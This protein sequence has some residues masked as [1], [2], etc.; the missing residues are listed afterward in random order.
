[1]NTAGK[2]VVFLSL[3][4]KVFFF[5]IDYT[6]SHVRIRLQTK[7]FSITRNDMFCRSVFLSNSKRDSDGVSRRRSPLVKYP[8]ID[9]AP[10]GECKWSLIDLR[11]VI[12]L[13]LI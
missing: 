8:L 12:G 6:Y 1:M 9:G 7:K 2:L 5:H 3:I 13:C 11:S 10:F 4:G